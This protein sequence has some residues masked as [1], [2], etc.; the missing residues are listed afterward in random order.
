MRCYFYRSFG[1]SRGVLKPD[2]P[3]IFNDRVIGDWG[4]S[5]ASNYAMLAPIA[6]GCKHQTMRGKRPCGATPERAPRE[7]IKL[8]LL[9]NQ[10]I[11]SLKKLERLF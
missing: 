2:K 11:Y 9:K 5:G 6:F 3:A 4:N 1:A 10:P 8:N 7:E